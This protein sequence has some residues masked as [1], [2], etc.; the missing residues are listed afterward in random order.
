MARYGRKTEVSRRRNHNDTYSEGRGECDDNGKS[1]TWCVRE[2]HGR[3]GG[4]KGLLIQE[5]KSG[6]LATTNDQFIVTPHTHTQVWA[7]SKGGY[8]MNFVKGKAQTLLACD[9]SDSPIV[10]V[11]GD[12]DVDNG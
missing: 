5:E 1:M 2:R 11:I 9:G 6:T 12:K 3:P 7:T 8:H 4:G 10:Y